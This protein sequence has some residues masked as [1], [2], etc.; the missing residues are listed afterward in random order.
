MKGLNGMPL[1][2]KKLKCHSANLGNKALSL[3][4]TP[5]AGNIGGIQDT[6]VKPANHAFGSYLLSYENIT[7]LDVQLTLMNEP[8]C[9]IP[10][11]VLQLL[12]MCYP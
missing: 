11:R 6:I 7:N 12:N 3:G 5:N 10:S 4:F 9:K 2:D 1:G 8:L